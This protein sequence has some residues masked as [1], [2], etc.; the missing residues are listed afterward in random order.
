MYKKAAIVITFFQVITIFLLS[1]CGSD[2]PDKSDVDLKEMQATVDASSEIHWLRF[3]EGFRK[4][5]EENRPMLV[6]FT[7]SWC[8]WCKKMDAETF[9]MPSVIREINKSFIPVRVWGDSD[10]ILS[11]N[12]IS[13]SEK[14]LTAQAGISSFPSFV[15]MNSSL[16]RIH[17][18]KGYHDSRRFLAELKKG[19]ENL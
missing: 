9:I 1:S 5:K 4:A 10:D 7:A 16:E 6:D 8:G 3:D 12:E 15:I 14:Q 13:V 19:Q 2:T 18:F 17:F 11:I